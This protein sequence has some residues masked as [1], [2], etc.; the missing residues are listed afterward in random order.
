MEDPRNYCEKHLR[1]GGVLIV[2]DV[3]HNELHHKKAH[4]LNAGAFF[5][6]YADYGGEDDNNPIY[7]L[8]KTRFWKGYRQILCNPAKMVISDWLL[9]VY[10]DVSEILVG[11]PVRL[12]SWESLLA[13]CNNDTTGTLRLDLW[14]DRVEACPF[15]T[16]AQV[17][18]GFAVLIAG[19]VS[20]DVWLEGCQH[21]L[22]WLTNLASFLVNEASAE[23][24]RR[25]TYRRSPH[26]LFL[27][28]SS[29]DKIAVSEVAMAIK[30]GGI[31]VWLDKEQLIPSQ[32]LTEEINRAFGKMTH[33]VLFWSSNCVG[34]P[35]V[36]RE[37]NAAITLL[38]EKKIPLIIVRLDQ[39][40]VPVICADLF[41]IEALGETGD[42]IGRRVVD[43][44]KRLVL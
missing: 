25:S 1:S 40:P 7:G 37:I 5:N 44:V 17:G 2:A 32:S 20:G 41:R 26:L 12:T 22:K 30:R 16:V 35:W 13:S 6:S 36:E 18:A 10:D 27:S 23:L 39:T 29:T 4:Y 19:G 9:P 24:K 8:D 28:H 31:N 43:A 42:D 3:D 15:A 38:I 11:L 34:R 33:F 21:N 14:I